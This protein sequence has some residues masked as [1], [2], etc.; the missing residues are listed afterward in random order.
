MCVCVC[1]CVWWGVVDGRV[2][3][4]G[5]EKMVKWER[6]AGPKRG[7]KGRKMGRKTGKNLGKRKEGLWRRAEG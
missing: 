4:E 3:G 6:G 1:A 2:E 7:M 5:Q